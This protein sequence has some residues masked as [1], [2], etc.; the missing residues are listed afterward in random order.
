MC[1]RAIA[2]WRRAA[3]LELL[4]LLAQIGANV[5]SRLP[6]R[7]LAHAAGERGGG[8]VALWLRVAC[9]ALLACCWRVAGVLLACC[10]R[11]AGVL[12]ALLKWR[13]QG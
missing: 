10:W 1:C 13:T 7:K 6:D 2:L 9:L 4:A 12:L 11:V 5:V 8:A 3:L